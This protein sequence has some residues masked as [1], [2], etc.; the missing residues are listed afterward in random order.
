MELISYRNIKLSFL[1]VLVMLATYPVVHQFSGVLGFSLQVHADGFFKPKVIKVLVNLVESGSQA[2]TAG[3]ALGDELIRVQD[4]SL[5][6][7]DTVF[8]KP[9]MEF[10][11]DTPKKLVLRKPNGQTYEAILIKP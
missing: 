6:G 9:H 7:T 2:E 4:L 3:L 10:L 5:P 1:L 8:L 11:K